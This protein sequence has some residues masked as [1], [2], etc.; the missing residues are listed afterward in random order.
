MQINNINHLLAYK[1]LLVQVQELA[2]KLP[3][4]GISSDDL[5]LLPFD[6]LI[7]TLSY[8]KHLYAER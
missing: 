1:Q 2:A 3:D 5:A 6:D 4:T 7:G 8:L